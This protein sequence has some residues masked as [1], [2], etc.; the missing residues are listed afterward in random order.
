MKKVAIEILRARLWASDEMPFLS[1][2][3]WAMSFH[4]VKGLMKDYG[5][6]GP[7]GVDNKWR[8]YYDPEGI[9]QWGKPELGTVLL[10][11]V[12][13]LVREHAERCMERNPIGWNLA[14]DCAINQDLKAYALPAGT[15]HPATFHLEEGHTAEWYYDQ[16]K[17]QA[18]S[19]E[20]KTQ[21]CGS[22]AHGKAQGY[23]LDGG[24]KEG[25]EPGEEGISK[26]EAD[27]IRGKVAQDIKEGNGIG[28]VSA[29]M[30]RWSEDYLNP[31]LDWRTLLAKY[32][33]SSVRAVIGCQ[34][35]SYKRPS[36]RRWGRVI[37]PRMIGHEAKVSIVVDTSGSM[38]KGEIG[39]CLG[40]VKGIAR[41]AGFDSPVLFVDTEVCSRG[42][43]GQD[44]STS[45]AGGGGTDMA[46]GIE[47]ALEDKVKPD[48]VIVLTDGV[49]GW[50]SVQPE[51]PV[52]IC[53]TPNAYEMETPDW[54]K[55][56]R[57]E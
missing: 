27:L 16:L 42:V 36:K 25:E 11:E 39:A 46:R 38:G 3:L 31:Q 45:V 21:N 57:L 2:A 13:H 32:I 4:E 55:V 22:C 8:C 37:L 28:R 41:A 33:R 30:R 24:G 35:Y 20:G 19:L 6:L 18:E 53:L 51:K 44:L 56:V 10:H 43:A 40:E 15:L 23:E 26:A 1:T 48:A 50:P 14:A 47:Q 7:M 5:A 17:D 9:K 54:A 52:I 12:M 29:G 49:T 34:D